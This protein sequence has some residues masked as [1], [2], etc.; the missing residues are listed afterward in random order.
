MEV[1]RKSRLAGNE[2]G[3]LNNLYYDLQTALHLTSISNHQVEY[4]RVVKAMEDLDR[5]MNLVDKAFLAAVEDEHYRA[6][7][8]ELEELEELEEA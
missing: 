2:S 4:P 5:L 6:D 1:T 7:M 8:V 3:V